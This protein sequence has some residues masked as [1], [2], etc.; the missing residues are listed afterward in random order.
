MNTKHAAMA[1]RALDQR[2]SRLTDAE[3][4][5]LP[6]GGWIRAVREALGMSTSRLGQRMGVTRQAV[7]KFEKQE[8]EGSIGLSTLRRA[9]EALDCQLVYAFVPKNSLDETVRA[10]ARRVAIAELARVDQTMLLEGQRVVRDEAEER[11][12]QRVE[13]LVASRHLWDADVPAEQ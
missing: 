7:L 9:A 1:R 3:M 11:L 5:A 2:T 13:E 12:A 6:A 4:S 8:I 10:Q